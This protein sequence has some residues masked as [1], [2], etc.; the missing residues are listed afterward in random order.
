MSYTADLCDAI[1]SFMDT[2]QRVEEDKQITIFRRISVRCLSLPSSNSVEARFLWTT[3]SQL[4]NY[5]ASNVGR[6]PYQKQF[7]RRSDVLKAN[8]VS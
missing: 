4:R 1:T 2:F 5:L 6:N 3:S 8:G 7:E